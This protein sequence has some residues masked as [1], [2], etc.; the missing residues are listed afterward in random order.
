MCHGAG[1]LVLLGAISFGV[2]ADAGAWPREEGKS[3][4]SFSLESYA[5]TNYLS[6]FYEYGL[7]PNLT[8]G[9]DAGRD[10]AA[11]TSSAIV[12]LR[13]PVLFG[14]ANVFA[15]ELGL[16]ETVQSGETVA[17]IRPGFYWGRGI[18][19]A[20]LSGW[21]GVE[22]TYAQGTN[23]KAL[24]KIQATIGANL[25]NNRLAILDLQYENP[26]TGESFVAIAPSHVFELGQ[27]TR[28]QI[29]LRHTIDTGET[30]AKIG[31]WID[32]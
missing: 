9:L 30:A 24:G 27:N 32:F 5:G 19:F 10:P 21:T 4:L 15:L 16:G 22:M 14:G 7:T 25:R 2:R 20:G 17:T 31:L 12:F 11:G 29:G 13:Y 23:G 18:D 1:C 6:L 28:F 3:F 26:S 8:L